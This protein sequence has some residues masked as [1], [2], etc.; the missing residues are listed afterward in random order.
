MHNDLA[1]LDGFYLK[2]SK[3]KEMMVLELYHCNQCL[4]SSPTETL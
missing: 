4:S 2:S 1:L 3:N